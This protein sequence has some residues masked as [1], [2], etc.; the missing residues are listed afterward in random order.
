MIG[1]RGERTKREICKRRMKREEINYGFDRGRERVS[2]V[3]SGFR[4]ET[5]RRETFV[6]KMSE[7]FIE[8]ET[9]M[10]ELRFILSSCYSS[11]C[12]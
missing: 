10:N 8:R 1:Q 7:Y 5:K 12:L 6:R 9:K 2:L 3:F 11:F 4:Q